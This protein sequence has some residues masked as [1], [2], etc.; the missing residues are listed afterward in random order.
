LL[1]TGLAFMIADEIAAPLWLSPFSCIR[2]GRT[3]GAR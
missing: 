3:S 1:S 2:L